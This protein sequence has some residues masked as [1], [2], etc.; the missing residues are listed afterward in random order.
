MKVVRGKETFL[1]IIFSYFENYKPGR[2]DQ[3]VCGIS[4]AREFIALRIG[5]VLVW[6]VDLLLKKS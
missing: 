3:S 5:L 2:T 4:P 6:N 1:R